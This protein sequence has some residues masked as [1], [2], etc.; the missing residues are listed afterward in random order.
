MNT[1][2]EL[3]NNWAANHD[4]LLATG[5]APISFEGEED[6][7]TEAVKQPQVMPDMSVLDLGV[8]TG[9]LEARFV[10]IGCDVWGMDFSEN[11]LVKA[12][13]KLPLCI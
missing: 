4:Q 11:T 7:L 9:N 3:F 2:K 10:T 8:G 6:V 5:N 13:E 1:G 12:Q